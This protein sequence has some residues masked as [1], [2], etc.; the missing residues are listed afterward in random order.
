MSMTEQILTLLYTE[1]VRE[2][3]GGTYGVYVSGALDKFPKESYN[4]QIMFD[5]DPAKKDKLMQI[6]LGEIQQIA[7]KGTTQENHSK[8]KEFMLK[9]HTENQKENG[10]WLG[11]IDEMLF[12]G[13][14]MSNEYENIV[15][16]ISNADIQKFASE[17][18]SQNNRVEISMISP[19]KKK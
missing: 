8:V 9:K 6:I 3:E 2:E 10:Y 16:A 5:T 14:N 15:N 18:F 19:E 17:I 7:D 11:Q 12:T 1:K 4:L 13:S